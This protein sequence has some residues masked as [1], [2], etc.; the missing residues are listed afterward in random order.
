MR[1]PIRLA[2]EV[3]VTLHTLSLLGNGFIITAIL[4]GAATAELIDRR[5]RA[6]A[7]Y[8]ITGAV[9][10]LFGDDSFADG[11][12]ERSC[13]RGGL[14]S[15]L[16]WHLAAAYAVAALTMAVAR[17]LPREM[18]RKLQDD[19]GGCLEVIEGVDCVVIAV[20]VDTAHCRGGGKAGWSCRLR[21]RRR[22]RGQ[23]RR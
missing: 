17:F 19:G 22:A 8:L 12:E 1:L 7:L 6:S 4:W 5:F 15:A 16:P 18:P 10:C 13:C 20:S 9:F 11:P 2:G 3:G 23:S 21:G 14:A